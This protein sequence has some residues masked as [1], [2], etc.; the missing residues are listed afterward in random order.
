MSA[1]ITVTG[2]T[3]ERMR[4]IEKSTVVD[5]RVTGDVLRLVTRAGE[6][7]E[8][9]YVRGSQG[10]RG[11][12]GISLWLTQAAFTKATTENVVHEDVPGRV[13]QLGDIIMS[14]HPTSMGFFGRVVALSPQ[15]NAT[16]AYVGNLRGPTGGSQEEFNN[17]FGVGIQQWSDSNTMSSEEIVDGESTLG[18]LLS[19]S[20]LVRTVRRLV[21]GSA[22]TPVTAIAQAINRAVSASAVR[23]QI[24]AASAESLNNRPISNDITSFRVM[25]RTAY[26]NLTTKSPTTLYLILG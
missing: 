14:T 4:Q 15:T 8:A 9:G 1:P 5:G 7:I 2:F 6:E 16:V 18:R 11:N 24:G 26:T 13:L 21:T 17:M 19:S 12:T 3:A 22:D 10:P 25:T 20:L 23:T